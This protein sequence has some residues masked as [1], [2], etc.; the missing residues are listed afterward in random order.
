M[1]TPAYL[2]GGVH[3]HRNNISECD[4]K[5][6]MPTFPSTCP[7]LTAVGGTEGF[8]PEVGV[9]FSSGGFS[10]YFP[11]LAYQSSAI[12]SFFTTLPTNFNATFNRTGRGF[13][14]LGAQ[15]LL[16]KIISSGNKTEADSG[17]SAS[18]LT[19]ASIIALINNRLLSVGKP[20][21][22]FLNPWLYASVT[23]G[24]FTDI[25]EGSNP[26]LVCFGPAFDAVKGW[27]PVTGLGTPLFDKLLAAAMA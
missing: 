24:G 2:K 3:G 6:L 11:A 1:L 13:P 12:S 15:S 27:D 22:G 9:D 21:L 8:D 18:A 25:T 5:T 14:H 26:G 20:V 4:N 16:F 7:Y 10:N 23:K 19:V 17:T